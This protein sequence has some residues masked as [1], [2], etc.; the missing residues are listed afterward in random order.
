[1]KTLVIRRCAVEKSDILKIG[2]DWILVSIWEMLKSFTIYRERTQ[3]GDLSRRKEIVASTSVQ[4]KEDAYLMD[5]NAH[6]SWS[7]KLRKFV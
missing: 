6:Q 2:L 3:T 4:L 5:P 7:G 1:M